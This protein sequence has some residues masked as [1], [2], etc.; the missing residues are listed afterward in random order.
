MG[1]VAFLASEFNKGLSFSPMKIQLFAPCLLVI[2]LSAC[3]ES[4]L[5]SHYNADDMNPGGNKVATVSCPLSFSKSKLCGSIEWVTGPSEEESVFTL[6]F[7]DSNE[8]SSKGPYLDPAHR[9]FVQLWMTSMGHGSSPVAIQKTTQ[10]IYAV[11]KVFFIMPGEWDVR[12][13]LKDGNVVFEQ[14]VQSVNVH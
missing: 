6:K 5:F 9:V 10:G 1:E 13:Q 2:F 3:G 7:W 14:T 8:G 12:V 4:P 11:T